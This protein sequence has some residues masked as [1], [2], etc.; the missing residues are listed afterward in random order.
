MGYSIN[1]FKRDVGGGYD[2]I[3]KPIPDPIKKY[4]D[5]ATAYKSAQTK[6]NTKK[7]VKITSFKAKKDPFAP[8]RIAIDDKTLG[9]LYKNTAPELDPYAN[10]PGG[11]NNIFNSGMG[12]N[13]TFRENLSSYLDSASGDSWISSLFPNAMGTRGAGERI[14]GVTPEEAKNKSNPYYKDPNATAPGGLNPQGMYPGSTTPDNKVTFPGED[15]ASWNG[16]IGADETAADAGSPIERRYALLQSNMR[17]QE[18]AQQG[19]EQ[20]A[21]SR[22]FAAMGATN[23]GAAIKNMQVS[24]DVGAKR[25]GEQSNMLAAQQSADQQGAIEAA[26]ARNMQRQGLRMG[27]EEEMRNRSLEQAK[28]AEGSRQFEKE[29]DLN[30]KIASQNMA[31]ARDALRSN[32]KGFIQGI[33][34]ELFGNISINSLTGGK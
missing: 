32:S 1:Q 11:L 18:R 15:K 25:L 8:P 34:G 3:N 30:S 29:F 7:P 27:S 9:N 2:A 10:A 22:R 13:K 21:L 20:D 6:L 5:P 28:I 31:I 12:I 17:G 16:L 23:S 19:M 24:R 33:F 26:N 14:T 4:V